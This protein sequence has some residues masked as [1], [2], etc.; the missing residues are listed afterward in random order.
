MR[1]IVN[2]RLESLGASAA[3]QESALHAVVAQVGDAADAHSRRRVTCRATG[4]HHHMHVGHA[5]QRT[6]RAPTQRQDRRSPGVIDN[7]CDRAVKI[8]HDKQWTP[9]EVLH[10][11]LHCTAQVVRDH[12]RTRP[13]D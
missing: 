1:G 9:C 10:G 11:Q 7:A 5:R 13:E 8:S 12:M 6:Q 3:A 4:Q 2:L